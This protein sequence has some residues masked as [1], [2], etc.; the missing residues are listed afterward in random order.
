MKVIPQAKWIDFSHQII[1]HGRALCTA[2]APKCAE[3]PLETLCHAADKTWS[4]VPQHKLAQ[5]KKDLRRIGP[6]SKVGWSRLRSQ[7]L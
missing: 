7:R 1:H 4:T 5:G 6:A 3:C 2:R